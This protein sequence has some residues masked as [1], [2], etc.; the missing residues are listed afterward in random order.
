[1]AAK[2]IPKN[3][4]KTIR[5]AVKT[6]GRATARDWI[7]DQGYCDGLEEAQ[8]MVDQALEEAGIVTFCWP[9][10]AGAGCDTNKHEKGPFE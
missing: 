6:A 4:N 9:D 8:K 10:H 5:S 2:H 1:M 7:V 3:L